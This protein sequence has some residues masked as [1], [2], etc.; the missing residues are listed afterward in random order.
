MSLAILPLELRIVLL[1]LDIVCGPGEYRYGHWGSGNSIVA[2]LEFANSIDAIDFHG[3]FDGA[4]DGSGG[5]AAF[6]GGFGESAYGHWGSGN[7]IAGHLEFANS[8]GTIDFHD[9]F[10][11]AIDSFHGL[12]E[13]LSTCSE[14]ACTMRLW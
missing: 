13:I 9:K 10:D 6:L 8:I 7:S 12:A 2:Y 5:P 4:I 14:S 11:D 1:I 3:K